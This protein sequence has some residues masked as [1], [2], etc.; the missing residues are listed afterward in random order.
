M[1][2]VS[3]LEGPALYLLIALIA[4]FAVILLLVVAFCFLS[5]SAKHFRT[6]MPF[7]DLFIPINDD[8]PHGA[9][10]VVDVGLV[11]CEVGS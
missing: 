10:G 3:L 11:D 6:L 9:T 2:A 7:A 5:P 4:L 1:P 8:E